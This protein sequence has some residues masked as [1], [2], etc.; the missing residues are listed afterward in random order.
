MSA[1]VQVILVAFP[2]TE[3]IVSDGPIFP[4][5][6]PVGRACDERRNLYR[7]GREEQNM[8]PRKSPIRIRLRVANRPGQV[9]RPGRG[10]GSYRR[11]T[12]K[13]HITRQLAEE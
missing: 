9:F 13:A 12:A 1:R 8:R 7:G 6:I 4:P 11:A 2:R 5:T 10:R 3:P